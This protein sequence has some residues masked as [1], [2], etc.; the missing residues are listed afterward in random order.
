MIKFE[1]ELDVCELELHRKLCLMEQIDY[2]VVEIEYDISKL[3]PGN[4]FRPAEG[5]ELED[6]SVKVTDGMFS[7]SQRK[8]ILELLDENAIVGSIWEDYEA[9]KNEVD[10]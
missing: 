6:W 3:V 4:W 2:V 9:N 8:K 10:W 7:L 1:T 5:G